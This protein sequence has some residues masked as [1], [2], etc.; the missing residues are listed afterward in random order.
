MCGIATIAIGRSCRKRIPYPLLRSLVKELMVELSPRGQD[1]SG[2][3]VV[4]EDECFVFK[5]PLRPKRFVVRP[6]FEE[7]LNQIGPNTN[8]VMLHSRAA[9]VGGNENNINNHPIIAGPVIGIHNGTL[10]NDG[11]LFQAYRKKFQPEGTVDSEII[12]RLLNMYL[13]NG[14]T[15]QRAMQLVSKQLV[16]AFTGAAVDMRFTN[17]MIMFKNARQLAVLRIPHYDTVVAVSEARFYDA[18]RRHLKIKAKDICVY[19]KEETGLLFDVNAGRISGELA[20]FRLPV[21]EECRRTNRRWGGGW[22]NF[23]E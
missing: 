2:I 9:S 7:T 13:Q 16:G 10:Y 3:A 20:D 1:A 11:R 23:I 22:V 18:A 5:K 21:Q 19:P 15:P 12:F 4:N 8:F 14:V 6:K 17:R